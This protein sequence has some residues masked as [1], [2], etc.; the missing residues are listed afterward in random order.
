M[1][2]LQLTNIF[3]FVYIPPRNSTGNTASDPLGH[4]NSFI[5]WFI[6][7]INWSHLL[8]YVVVLIRVVHSGNFWAIFSSFSVFSFH[9]FFKKE[10]QNEMRMNQKMVIFQKIEPYPWFYKNSHFHFH[11]HFSF[12]LC[13]QTPLWHLIPCSDHHWWQHPLPHTSTTTTTTPSHLPSPLPCPLPHW[14][15]PPT[16]ANQLHWAQTMTD[17]VWALGNVFFL[18]SFLFFSPN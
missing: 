5:I 7:N 17:V 6:F 8:I 12:S 13:F 10:L 14:L 18:S 2:F 16:T 9:P 1:L 15:M 11:F 3:H 4:S